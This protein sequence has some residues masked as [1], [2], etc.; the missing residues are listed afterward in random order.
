MPFDSEKYPG[1]GGPLTFQLSQVE[2]WMQSVAAS[3][4]PPKSY[5]S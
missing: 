4:S 5:F 2:G 3:V 1:V